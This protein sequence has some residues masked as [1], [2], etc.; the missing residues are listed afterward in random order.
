MTPHDAVGGGDRG[1]LRA[2]RR[3]LTVL[4]LANLVNYVDRAVPAIVLEPIAREFAL[5]D[6]EIG[7]LSAAGV[8]VFGL[9]G[10]PLG[11]VADRASR[12]RTAGWL[13]LVW[14]GFT[15]ATGASW[16]LL[17][18]VVARLGVSVGEAGYAPAANSLI[19]DLFRPDERARASGWFMLGLPLGLVLAYS[20]VGVLVEAF[21]S[22]RAPFLV[23]AVPGLV[24]A[25]LLFR[26]PE[27][28]R[29]AGD[30]LEEV[31]PAAA[32]GPVRRILAVPTFRW[33]VVGGIGY[34][35]AAYGVNT[36]MVALMQ[37]WFGLSLTA[38]ATATA[39]IIGVTGLVALTLGGALGDRAYRRS[40]RSRV[41][42]GAVAVLAAAPLTTGALL[43]G[44]DAAAAFTALFATGW[45]LGYLFVTTVYP[46]VADIVEPRRRGVAVALLFA[47]QFLLG[48][49]A[50][51]LV[52]GGLSDALAAGAVAGGADPDAAR[53]AGL[54]DALFLVPA[55]L[56]LA[57]LALLAAA[58]TVTDDVVRMR[59]T[60]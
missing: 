34:N 7:L 4:F 37:R 11:R 53:A 35:F 31:P 52:V 58:R 45:L 43:L 54:H 28:R 55:A 21:G 8:V 33:L 57:G 20:F 19:G 6:L 36:F 48:G 9:A 23:A 17:T 50:G 15:A 39:V 10:L 46:T 41:L 1:R 5:G 24:V 30:D 38:G 27:P 42:L 49:A 25:V 26:L 2:A 13:V 3:A 60:A 44:R 14:S 59:S 32:G 12:T 51:P 40:V 47:L 29:G 18:L 56:L 22:W 16:N